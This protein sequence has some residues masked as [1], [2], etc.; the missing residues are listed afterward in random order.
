MARRTISA[1]V[2]AQ[3]LAAAQVEGVRLPEV[4]KQFGVSLPTVYNWLKAATPVLSETTT[5]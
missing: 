4:A 1:E 3:V 2:R 5:V